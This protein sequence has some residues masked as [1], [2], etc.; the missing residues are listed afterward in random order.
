MRPLLALLL[1]AISLPAAAQLP[2]APRPVPGSLA[3]H[4]WAPREQKGSPVRNSGRHKKDAKDI[5]VWATERP[6]WLRRDP[7]VVATFTGEDFARKKETRV[8]NGVATRSL[9]HPHLTWFTSVKPI[10]PQKQACVTVYLK[11]HPDFRPG[12]GGKLPG[13]SNTGL[14]RRYTSIPEVVNGRKLK[15][16]GWGGRKPDGIHWSA[17]TGFGQWDEDS[18]TFR[19]YFYAMSPKN[20]W[21]HVDR[22]GELPRGEWTGYIQ[23]IK[24]NTPGEADGSLYYEVLGGGDTYARNDIRWRD[25]DVPES[26]IR[27]LWLDFY[28]GGTKCGDGPRGTVSFARAVVTKGLPDPANVNATLARLKRDAP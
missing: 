4:A 27:E 21:G 13:F 14:G 9:E 25:E 18:V 6:A 12:S 22:F 19:T 16:T 23:C 3:D 17:R 8:R 28:C 11:L 24:L 10:P 15:N 7:R 5:R 1:A 26:L 2:P 20:I